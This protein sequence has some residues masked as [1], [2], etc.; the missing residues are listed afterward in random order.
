MGWIRFATTSKSRTPSEELSED[1]DLVV[2]GASF[3]CGF[4]LRATKTE[5]RGVAYGSR[6]CLRHRQGQ[7]MVTGS[8]ERSWRARLG[9]CQ[10][11]PI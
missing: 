3:P 2:L 4:A 9:P 10:L 5:S 8:R 1:R 6:A 7:T 11:Q